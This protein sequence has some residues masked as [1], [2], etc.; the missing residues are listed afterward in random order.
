M[1][2]PWIQFFLNNSETLALLV[3]HNAL[4]IAAHAATVNIGIHLEGSIFRFAQL[5]STLELLFRHA[6][7]S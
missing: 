2:A 3:L 4:V 6:L 5:L 7:S 1:A